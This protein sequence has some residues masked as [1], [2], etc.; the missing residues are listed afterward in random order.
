MNTKTIVILTDFGLEDN[1][2]GV[3]KGVMI[4]IAPSIRLIDLSHSVKPHD[5]LGAAI[6]LKSS[7]RFFPEKAIFLVVVDPGVG[8]KRKS[9]IVKTNNH[10]FV[11]PDNGVLSLAAGENGVK[12]IVEIKKDKYLLKPLSSTFHGRDIFAP[13]AAHLA[14]GEKI[15]NFGPTLKKIS[16]AHIP[17]PKFNEDSLTGE[18]IYIDKFGNLVS[19]IDKRLLKK[20]AGAKKIKIK[21]KKKF[22]NTISKSYLQSRIGSPLAIFGSFGFLEISINKGSAKDYFKIKKGGK[23]TIKVD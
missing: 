13:V 20:F 21:I 6:L 2:V 18:I 22:I 15:N 8:S 3:M 9:V 16:Q 5:I 1:F 19:N 11:G 4:K 17:E 12:K 14:K 23:F 10:F 7:F